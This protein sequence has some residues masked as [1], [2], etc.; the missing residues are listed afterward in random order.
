MHNEK[1]GT[2]GTGSPV[3]DVAHPDGPR[4]Y[5]Q[6]HVRRQLRKFYRQLEYK[7]GWYGCELVKIDL[8]FY[9]SSNAA[10][11]VNT[12]LE[13]SD[14]W[15]VYQEYGIPHERD[16]NAARSIRDSFYQYDNKR[17]KTPSNSA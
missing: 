3:R 2:A 7:G 5:R 17:Q 16:T 8:W 12:A 6:D 13:L 14:K 1:K 9:P 15:L 4:P 10:R 11:P